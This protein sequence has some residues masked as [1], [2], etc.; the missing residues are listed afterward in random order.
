MTNY[1]GRPEIDNLEPIANNG[2]YPDLVVG[3]FV[4]IYR[5][6]SEYKAFVITDGLQLAMIEINAQLSAFRAAMTESTLEDY[7]TVHPEA[8]GDEPIL[9]KKY[10]EAV[11]CYAKAQLLQ[12]FKTFIRKPEAENLAKESEDTYQY[13]LERSI[14]AVQFLFDVFGISQRP[15]ISGTVGVYLI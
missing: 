7:C 10:K 13:W 11:F 9:I 2:F 14:Q 1:T 8:I 12:Q 6:P 4:A 3:E 15:T 5:I